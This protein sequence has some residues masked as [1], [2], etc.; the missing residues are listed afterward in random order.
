MKTTIK[1][2]IQHS[3]ILAN[4]LTLLIVTMIIVPGIILTIYPVTYFITKSAADDIIKKYESTQTETMIK[5]KLS[6]SFAMSYDIGEII[7]SIE[8]ENMASLEIPD[9]MTTNLSTEDAQSITVNSD[10]DIKRLMIISGEIYNNING[11]L[12][13]YMLSLD[14]CNIVVSVNDYH[15]NLTTTQDIDTTSSLYQMINEHRKSIEIY[16]GDGQVIGEVGIAM[17]PKLIQMIIIPYAVLLV[18]VSLLSI[19]IVKAVSSLMSKGIMRP[20]NQ[21]NKQLELIANYE[22]NEIS[23]FTLG[24]K[25]P[26]AEIDAMIKSSN[27]IYEKFRALQTTLENQNDELTVQNDELI[28][29]REIIETQQKQLIQN[30]KLASVGQITAAIVHEINTPIG[31]IKSN[32]QMT[33]MVLSKISNETDVDKIHN[34]CEKITPGNR[35]VIDAS[36]RVIEIIKSIKNFS[37]ID[38]SSFKEADIKEGLDSVLL[39]TSNLW[40]SRIEIIRNYEDLP[41]VLCYASLL[42]QVFMNI[43]TNAI[44]AIEGPGHIWIDAFIENENL[45]VKIRDDGT[46]MSPEICRKIFE[47]GYTTKPIGKGSGLGLA[48]S[49]DIIAKHSGTIE[50]ESK[51]GIGTTFKIIIPH[52]HQ[53]VLKQF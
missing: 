28:H 9:E 14:I 44:D 42:N 17:D 37:R 39:L 50:V 12:R 13:D 2:K 1:Q 43:I 15:L 4:L 51:P 3:M 18:V 48:L 27:V 30:E 40:K 35:L 53:E 21:L 11:F 38:Q 10:E 25:K 46:G 26:P 22:V 34:Q 20:I 33:E 36:D 41:Q 29:N 23:R 45:I 7:A 49:K 16:D 19:V 47:Q 5:S 6:N 24:I 8:E 32:A 31:A 52:V